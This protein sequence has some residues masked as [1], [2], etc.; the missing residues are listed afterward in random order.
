[1]CSECEEEDPM[2][3]L[4]VHQ[5]RVDTLVT[6]EAIANEIAANRTQSVML[7]CGGYPSRSLDIIATSFLIIV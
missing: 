7:Q 6:A 4:H 5:G 3:D 2:A 1:M